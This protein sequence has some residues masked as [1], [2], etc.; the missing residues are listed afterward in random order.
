MLR[1][2]EWAGTVIEIPL[3]NALRTAY[4]I[5]QRPCVAGCDL[6]RI[7]T[8]ASYTLAVSAGGNSVCMSLTRHQII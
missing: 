4:A 3:K 1:E 8:V 5:H 2:F 7:L 6:L